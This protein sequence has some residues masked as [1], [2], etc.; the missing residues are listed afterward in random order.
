MK[1]NNIL[2]PIIGMILI[3]LIIYFLDINKTLKIL[4]SINFNYFIYAN[5]IVFVACIVASYR[6]KLI[7]Q[8]NKVSTSIFSGKNIF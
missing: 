3:L 8:F 2:R 7:L 4:K 5:I 1:L 6:L